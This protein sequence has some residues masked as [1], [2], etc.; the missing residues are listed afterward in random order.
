MAEEKSY[1]F[2]KPRNVQR[3]LWTLYIA[4]GLALLMD[5]VVHRHTE[6]PWE[7][8]PG[9]YPIYGFIGCSVL[10]IVAKWMRKLI[11]RPEDYYQQR[12][13]PQH[14]DRTDS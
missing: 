10:V 4:S 8:M 13:L 1:L 12:D 2:D 7:G 6:H 3:V 11:I 14:P 5:H 9:F